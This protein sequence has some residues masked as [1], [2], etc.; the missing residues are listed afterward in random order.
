MINKIKLRGGTGNTPI[1]V[2]VKERE[3]NAPPKPFS[4]TLYSYGDKKIYFNSQRF[5]RIEENRQNVAEVAMLESV[6]ELMHTTPLLVIHNPPVI[7]EGS[8]KPIA[9]QH[10]LVMYAEVKDGIPCS[11][12]T[13]WDQQEEAVVED[14][15]IDLMQRIGVSNEYSGYMEYVNNYRSKVLSI[16]GLSRQQLLERQQSSDVMGLFQLIGNAVIGGD[17]IQ[18][19]QIAVGANLMISIAN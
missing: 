17:N 12:I 3:C 13:Y 2:S 6:H 19:D 1:T 15:T 8:P 5:M 9:S 7:I 11:D 10:G 14:A 4:A 18:S 16:P